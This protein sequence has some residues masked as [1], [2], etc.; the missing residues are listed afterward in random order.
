MEPRIRIQSELQ[1]RI[2]NSLLHA[3]NDRIQVV[4]A[5]LGSG[6]THTVQAMADANTFPVLMAFYTR[7]LRDKTFED[8]QWRYPNKRAIK[9]D[10]PMEHVAGQFGI[11]ERKLHEYAHKNPGTYFEKVLRE[12]LEDVLSWAPPAVSAALSEYKRWSRHFR[13]Q[14]AEF[15][16]GQADILF[17]SQ[18]GLMRRIL[19]GHNF[20]IPAKV[21]VVLDELEIS[22]WTEDETSAHVNARAQAMLAAGGRWSILTGDTRPVRFGMPLQFLVSD[23]IKK[24]YIDPIVFHSHAPLGVGISIRPPSRSHSARKWREYRA[25]EAARNH[26]NRSIALPLVAA[27]ERRIAELGG[28]TPVFVGNVGQDEFSALRVRSFESMKGNN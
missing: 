28:K 12:Y 24:Q 27:E 22:L 8:F 18:Q 5:P 9:I 19:D 16:D 4:C 25:L 15:F 10:S 20:A 6:K 13:L 1:P 23:L 3:P 14:M 11:D 17:M 21:N 7:K 2:R 26:Q